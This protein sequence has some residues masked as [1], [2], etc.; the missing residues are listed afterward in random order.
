LDYRLSALAVETFGQI[1]S[2]V[3]NT[4][5]SFISRF[6]EVSNLFIFH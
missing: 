4:G 5:A 3:N 6:D 2:L 1:D